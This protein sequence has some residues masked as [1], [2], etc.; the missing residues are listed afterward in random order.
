MQIFSLPAFFSTNERI[1]TGYRVLKASTG[2]SP[3]FF[4]IE[5]I[6]NLSYKTEWVLQNKLV[7]DASRN[8]ISAQLTKPTLRKSAITFSIF[9]N[10]YST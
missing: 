2:G 4:I 5:E 9:E 10:N 7:R 3:I 6:R 8:T 1:A